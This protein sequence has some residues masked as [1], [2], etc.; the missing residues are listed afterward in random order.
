M[1]LSLN[2]PL[3]KTI[4]K[5]KRTSLAFITTLVLTTSFFSCKKI[6]FNEDDVILGEAGLPVWQVLNTENSSLLSD[7]IDDLK[8]QK[9]T[10]TM[11]ILSGDGLQSFKDG[12]FT[13]QDAFNGLNFSEFYWDSEN[14][15]LFKANIVQTETTYNRFNTST[16]EFSA[17]KELDWNNEKYGIDFTYRT[18][19]SDGKKGI[20]INSN[21]NEST[22]FF[23]E[24]L[25]QQLQIDEQNIVTLEVV[26]FVLAPDTT[27]YIVQTEDEAT[28]WCALA[29]SIGIDISGCPLEVGDPIVKNIEVALLSD[30]SLKQFGLKDGIEKPTAFQFFKSDSEIASE[31]NSIGFQN[32]TFNDH[33]CTVYPSGKICNNEFD[34]NYQSKAVDK[35]KVIYLKLEDHLLIYKDEQFKAIPFDLGRFHFITIDGQVYLTNKNILYKIDETNSELVELYDSPVDC[36]LFGN[37]ELQGFTEINGK[38]W[39]TNCEHIVS[40]ENDNCESV[41]IEH[42]NFNLFELRSNAVEVVDDNLIWIGYNTKG[43]YLVEWDKLVN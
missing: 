26:D 11:W 33:F 17:A 9:S 15:F 42:P 13:K 1:N 38:L 24:L 23:N 31:L 21:G 37:Q 19:S 10:E 2:K 43:I 6:E 20:S 36:W 18:T 14:T 35:N 4:F 28:A 27:K 16:G 34:L 32:F 40:C 30:G 39:I 41:R 25:K 5:M 3:T 22:F 12:Q 7:H 8:Y 29:D